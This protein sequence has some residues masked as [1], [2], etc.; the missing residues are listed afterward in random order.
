MRSFAIAAAALPLTGAW[1]CHVK[2]EELENVRFD[3]A[4]LGIATGR[5]RLTCDLTQQVADSPK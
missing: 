5:P 3:W 1:L 2:D 4:Q